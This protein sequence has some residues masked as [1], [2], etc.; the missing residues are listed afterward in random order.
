MIY[1]SVD[2][3]PGEVTQAYVLILNPMTDRTE[4]KLVAAAADTKEELL[5]L[6]HDNTVDYYNDGRW[7]KGYK[8]DG[9]LEWFN[10][11]SCDLALEMRDMWGHGIF[12]ITRNGWSMENA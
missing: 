9:P 10:R 3:I 6:V 2:A 8:Q 5:T 7:T 11:P 12:L 4:A 1:S